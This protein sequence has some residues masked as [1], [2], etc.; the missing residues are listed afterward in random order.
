MKARELRDM[1]PEELEQRLRETRQ[2]LLHLRIQQASGQ[3]EKPSRI[4]A[5][6]RDVARMKTVASERRKAAR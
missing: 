4:R 2:D 5:V 6:R 1:T 3:I